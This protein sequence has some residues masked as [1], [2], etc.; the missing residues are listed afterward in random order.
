MTR[1]SNPV[2]PTRSMLAHWILAAALAFGSGTIAVSPAWAAGDVEIGAFLASKWCSGCHLVETSGTGTDAAP[3]FQSIARNRGADQAW[4]RAWLISPHPP[5]P[6][7]NLS[8]LEIDDLVAY[9]AS[10]PKQ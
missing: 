8:R 3:S 5:M 9:L 4:L 1:T 2:F 7:L 6:N 10:L